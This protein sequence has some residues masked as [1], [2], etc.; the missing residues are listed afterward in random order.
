MPISLILS[1]D[2]SGPFF[3][4]FLWLFPQ[5]VCPSIISQ[6]VDLTRRNEA[7]EN[8]PVKTFRMTQ[9]TPA[10]LCS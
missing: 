4:L 10:V 9:V 3:D 6:K 2:F 8:I 7:E 1:D 5:K